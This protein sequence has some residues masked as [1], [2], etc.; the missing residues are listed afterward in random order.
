[1]LQKQTISISNDQLIDEK[2]IATLKRGDRYKL[3]KLSI[4]ID[5]ENKSRTEMIYRMLDEMP[6]FEICKISVTNGENELIN[7]LATKSMFKTKQD[8]F[9]IL[10]FSNNDRSKQS[11]PYEYLS[12]VYCL[13]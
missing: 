3:F 1:M 8:L 5:F 4:F 6:E 12:R 7:A 10:E 11:E 13:N 9:K 2:T